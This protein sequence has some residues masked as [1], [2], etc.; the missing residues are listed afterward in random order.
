MN[1]EV[2]HAPVSRR[3]A[4]EAA[5]CGVTPTKSHRAV[6]LFPL[7][8]TKD[9]RLANPGQ[10]ERIARATPAATD[11]FVFC[12]GWLHDE[13]EARN[14]AARFFALLDVAMLPVRERVRPL[15][16]VLHWPSTP[17]ADPELTRPVRVGGRQSDHQRRRRAQH[18]DALSD[19][20]L[21]AALWPDLERQLGTQARRNSTDVTSLLL[22]MARAEIPRAPEEEVELDALIRRPGRGEHRGAIRKLLFD[23]AD[24]DRLIEIWK[25]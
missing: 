18:F 15:H 9:G 21:R 22:A 3:S 24:L 8:L 23:R 4:R 10:L 14:E 17:F 5:G 13:T 2:H 11:I 20:A 19:G 12:H 1:D 7:T 25:M 16:V 6:G